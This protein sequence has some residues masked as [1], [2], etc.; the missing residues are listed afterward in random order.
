MPKIR[1]P[2]E[3]REALQIGQNGG[4]AR[5]HSCC[6]QA[7]SNISTPFDPGALAAHAR[8]DIAVAWRC[9]LHRPLRSIEA[10]EK[11]QH[12]APNVAA[13]ARRGGPDHEKQLGA[14]SGRRASQGR[15]RM[16]QTLWLQLFR[17]FPCFCH[18]TFCGL[19]KT[20]TQN[21]HTCS[22]LFLPLESSV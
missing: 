1:A 9:A 20:K 2:F 16:S 3:L 15:R 13:R 12:W 19:S 18:L 14:A 6:C 22:S 7:F 11:S 17:H 10:P 8:T 5:R 4:N 21:Q